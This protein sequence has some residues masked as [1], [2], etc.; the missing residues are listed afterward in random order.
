MSEA[1]DLR[2]G[3]IIPISNE[4]L[5]S[6]NIAYPSDF[7]KYSRNAYFDIL[8]GSNLPVIDLT[9]HAATL[10]TASEFENG[11]AYL[12]FRSNNV[13]FFTILLENG[14][15][16]FEPIKIEGS[17]ISVKRSEGKYVVMASGQGQV[18]LYT[19][20]KNG[21]IAEIKDIAASNARFSCE[22]AENVILVDAFTGDSISYTYYNLDLTPLFE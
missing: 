12:I 3:K 17:S 15:F 16:A 13:I 14:E 10:S 21:K 4:L 20:D 7:W 5:E 1:L 19:F 11:E 8:T 2:T 18:D 6:I 22:I 9:K